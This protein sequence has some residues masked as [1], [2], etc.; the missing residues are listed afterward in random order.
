MT[1]DAPP[2][3]PS[4][5]TKWPFFITWCGVNYGDFVN[6]PAAR[7]GEL[8]ALLKKLCPAHLWQVVL[9]TYV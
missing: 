8:E 9:A 1:R 6:I 3:I 4:D 2:P 5:T 7:R